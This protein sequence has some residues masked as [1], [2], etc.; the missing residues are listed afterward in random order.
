MRQIKAV[1]R[2]T[3]Q[4]AALLMAKLTVPVAVSE[5]LL[6]NRKLEEDECLALHQILSDME[7]DTAFLA[8]SMAIAELGC[9]QG[10]R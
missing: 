2:L 3:D 5:I 6:E 8:M 10:V 7:P 1:E 9:F 4:Q